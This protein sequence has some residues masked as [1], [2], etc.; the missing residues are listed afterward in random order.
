[1]KQEHA[2]VIEHQPI[3]GGYNLLVMHAP[4]IAPDVRP[5]QFVHVQVPHLNECVLRR[6]FS[7]FKTE[8]QRL[9]ILYKDVGKG[10]RTLGN[11][12][13]GEGLNLIGPLGR[14]FPALQ[15]GL[16]P[17]L[18]AGGYGM[19]ALYQT[20]RLLPVKGTA[21]FGGR[22]GGDILCVSEFENL[23]WDV[24][25]T[26]EDGSLGQ[27]GRVTDALDPWMKNELGSREPEL[28]ACGPTGMLNAVADRAL[29]QGWTAWISMDTNMGCGV[30]ACLT[31]VV[32]VHDGRGGWSWAR[33]CREGPVFECRELFREPANVTNRKSMP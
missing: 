30:G 32:K 14:G 19:A 13:P 26:T 5:G 8:G 12:R 29:E 10:T 23:G 11:L 15:E 7:V 25:I 20:A 3:Q 1:M 9:A 22:T 16:Y 6:P 27:A 21:F 2:E 24:R 28:F 33:S 4:G 31:C 17:V 18:V